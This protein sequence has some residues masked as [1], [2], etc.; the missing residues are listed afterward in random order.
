MGV[1]ELDTTEH[2]S[3]TW[4]NISPNHRK[5]NVEIN[6]H[7]GGK[8]SGIQVIFFFFKPKRIGKTF[9]ELELRDENNYETLSYKENKQSLDYTHSSRLIDREIDK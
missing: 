4:K 7:N 2:L 1:K 6:L 3:T 5:W 8:S 9:T